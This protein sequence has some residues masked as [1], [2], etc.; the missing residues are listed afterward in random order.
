MTVHA[1]ERHEHASHCAN[2]GERGW[3][4]GPRGGG[5]GGDALSMVQIMQMLL[6]GHEHADT[7][8]TGL[9]YVRWVGGVGGGDHCA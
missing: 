8:S 1:R 7:L 4:M 5:G 9:T 3:L 2:A 6:E